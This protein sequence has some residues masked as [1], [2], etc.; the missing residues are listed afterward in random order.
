MVLNTFDSI[1]VIKTFE[2]NSIRLSSVIKKPLIVH[3]IK[4]NKDD[5]IKLQNSIEKY[6]N[7]I[8]RGNIISYDFKLKARLDYAYLRYNTPLF[9]L[10][11]NQKITNGEFINILPGGQVFYSKKGYP[12]YSDLVPYILK[13]Q[14]RDKNYFSNMFIT[15]FLKSS[16]WLWYALNKFSN[17]DFHSQKIFKCILLPKINPNRET[18]KLIE[19]IEDNFTKIIELEKV[20]LTNSNKIKD[21]K[22]LN[23]IIEEHNKTIDE[24]AYNIDKN[25]Y[26]LCRLSDNDIRIIE[27]YLSNNNIYLPVFKE[28]KLYATETGVLSQ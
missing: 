6:I 25:I 27:N 16:F 19:L 26:K 18:K 4:I 9:Y 15:C 1:P 17:F 12:F 13:I 11:T 10:K 28:S 22:K 21:S 3:T 24:L 8:V 7:G 23:L 5:K 20:F 14:S 2:Y